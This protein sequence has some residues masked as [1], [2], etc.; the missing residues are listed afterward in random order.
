M[1]LDVGNKNYVLVDRI[2]GFIEYSNN[3]VRRIIRKAISEKPQSV[4]D[5]TKNS[6]DILTAIILTGDRYI[7]TSLSRITLAKRLG[8]TEDQ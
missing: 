6:D 5:V 1:L 3:N 2:I 7:L 4:I 8:L